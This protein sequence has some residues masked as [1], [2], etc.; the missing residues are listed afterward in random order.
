MQLKAILKNLG[1]GFR[2][3][4]ITIVAIPVCSFLYGL[5]PQQIHLYLEWIMLVAFLL[6]FIIFLITL[7]PAM[8]IFSTKKSDPIQIPELY[9][10]AKKMKY[11][12]VQ[13]PFLI[14]DKK[15]LKAQSNQITKK[16][17]FGSGFYNDLSSEEKIFVG[18]HEFWHI[19]GNDFFYFIII[20][21]LAVVISCAIPT[22][23]GAPLPVS[24]S[25]MIGFV[26]LSVICYSRSSELLAD[27]A[28]RDHVSKE[29][30]ASALKKAYP[31][32]TDRGFYLHPS[33][34]ERI[35]RL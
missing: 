11:E 23:F 4:E 21:I 26:I 9:H 2:I 15:N 28:G 27:R 19:Y 10:L 16:I 35:K 8:N 29:V 18:G 34:D 24:V 12:L 6:S 32:K 22:H 25:G 3:R 1:V 14:V 33:V 31:G 17:T 7:R 20:I 5:V 13:N 30:A